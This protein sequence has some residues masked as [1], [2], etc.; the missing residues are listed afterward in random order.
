MCQ[1]I[2]NGPAADLGAV[3]LEGVQSQ[4]FRGREAVRARR[5]AS[6]TFLEEVSDRLR[7]GCGVVATRSSGDP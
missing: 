4:G 1:T 5:G 6:Q 3:E 2:L 7:P